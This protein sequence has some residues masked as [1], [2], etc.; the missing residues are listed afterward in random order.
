MFYHNGKNCF[1]PFFFVRDD[2][3][4]ALQPGLA[5]HAQG[6]CTASA[7]AA[8][9]RLCH[10]QEETIDSRSHQFLA[11]KIMTFFFCH[12]RKCSNTVTSDMSCV[13]RKSQSRTCDLWHCW[14]AVGSKNRPHPPLPCVAP[15]RAGLRARLDPAPQVFSHDPWA[16]L[17]ALSVHRLWRRSFCWEAA[18]FYLYFLI[19]AVL[20]GNQHRNFRVFGKPAT[21]FRIVSEPMHICP[22]SL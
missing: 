13:G 11:F 7:S 4:K 3:I 6:I 14:A 21:L 17:P 19:W 5:P 22:A 2:A 9:N 16:L 12:Q 1:K 10:P 15:R 8:G 18:L 20:L